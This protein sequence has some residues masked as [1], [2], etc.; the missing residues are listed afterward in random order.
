MDHSSDW[1]IR[2][3]NGQCL[4]TTDV[5]KVIKFLLSNESIGING[6]EI[7]VDGGISA[8]RARSLDF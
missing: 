3:K 6:A 1:K 2:I 7:I 5:S 4:S 8:L